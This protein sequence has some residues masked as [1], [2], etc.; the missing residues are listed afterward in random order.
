MKTLCKG[1]I[2]GIPAKLKDHQIGGLFHISPTNSLSIA[3]SFPDIV[4]KEFF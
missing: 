4:N 2:A 3:S 1:T